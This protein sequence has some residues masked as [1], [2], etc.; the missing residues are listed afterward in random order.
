M[1]IVCRGTGELDS[2]AAYRIPFGLFYVVPTLIVFL[3]WKI[4][5]VSYFKFS[6]DR[7]D[8][9]CSLLDG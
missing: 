2:S 8:T 3:I 4:P 5:E 9:C 6:S 7:A 1:S